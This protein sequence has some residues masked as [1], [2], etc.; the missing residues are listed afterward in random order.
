MMMSLKQHVITTSGRGDTMRSAA[1]PQRETIYFHSH[2]ITLQL[3]FT[4]A[5]LTSYNSDHK[6]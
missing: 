2:Y 5:A 4:I 1:A 3:K 6:P